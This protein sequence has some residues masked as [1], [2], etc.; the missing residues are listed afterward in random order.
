MPTRIPERRPRRGLNNW[1]VAGMSIGFAAVVLLL[2]VAASD[3]DKAPQTRPVPGMK[4]PVSP[5]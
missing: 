4:A 2:A 3:R 5:S 1:L